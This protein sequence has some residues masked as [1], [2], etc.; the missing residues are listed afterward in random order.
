MSKSSGRSKARG[1][2]VA[3]PV[4]SST[5]KPAGIV[6]PSNSRVLDR[7]A[8]LVL[9]RRQQPED[10]LDGAAGSASRSSTTC[11]HWSGCGVEQHDGVADE[12]GDGL[13]AGP[14]EQRRRTRRSRRRSSP[15]SVPSPRSTVTWVRRRQHV[16]GRVS[17]ASP[18]ELVEVARP[19]SSMAVRCPRASGPSRPARGAG[20]R[21]SHSRIC[22][23]SPSGTPSIR[24]MISTGNG[25]E[26]SCDHVEGSPRPSSVVEQ[27]GDDLAD[28]RL[29]RRDGPGR[30][31]PADEGPEPVVLGR[32]HH[33]DHPERPDERRRPGVSVDSSTPCALENPFQSRWAATTSAKR[34]S[35]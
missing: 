8:A 7:E 35:A 28:H 22:C 18:R 2:R 24:E 4:S 11:C 10:L 30:E 26:K 15:V 1:S 9:R 34:D 5:G 21:S 6:P 29:E 14:A 19:C 20:T 25:A 17:A 31:H 23:R 3:A 13:G 33:D 27:P 12:L 32:V 16:V